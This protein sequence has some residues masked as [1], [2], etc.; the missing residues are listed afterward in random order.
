MD[1]IYI[2]LMKPVPVCDYLL[3]KMTSEW[4]VDRKEKENSIETWLFL[5]LINNI[6]IF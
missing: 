3:R 6:F 2:W 5:L 4:V 1:L